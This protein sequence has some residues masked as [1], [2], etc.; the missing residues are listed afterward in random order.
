MRHP[1]RAAPVS[2]ACHGS[3]NVKVLQAGVSAGLAQPAHKAGGIEAS[4][5]GGK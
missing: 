1:K 2:H 4:G 3:R 5:A